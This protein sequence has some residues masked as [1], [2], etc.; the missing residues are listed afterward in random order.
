MEIKVEDMNSWSVRKVCMTDIF[1]NNYLLFIFLNGSGCVNLL[2]I[3][4]RLWVC[5]LSFFIV[6]LLLMNNADMIIK[7]D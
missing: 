6:N 3:Q 2:H 7:N 5:S 1:L 4:S